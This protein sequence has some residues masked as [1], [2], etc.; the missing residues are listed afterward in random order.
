LNTLLALVSIAILVKLGEN[1][2]ASIYPTAIALIK[3]LTT[4]LPLVFKTTSA[5]SRG[6]SQAFTYRIAPITQKKLKA[7]TSTVFKEIFQIFN[8]SLIN[9]FGLELIDYR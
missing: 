6:S 2:Q 1:S 5:L 4:L 7:L 9:K 3:K 8:E